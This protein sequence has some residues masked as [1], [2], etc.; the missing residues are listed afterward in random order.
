MK[1]IFKIKLK[2]AHDAKGLTAY[3]VAKA[4][5]LSQ[6]TVRKYVDAKDG[7]TSSYVPAVVVR[8]A[9][10]YG[11]DWRN[12]EIVEVIE[13]SDDPSARATSLQFA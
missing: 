10:F 3:A 13:E 2:P 12:P 11:V 4:L 7:V 5:R 9:E 1:Q 6:A 8:L